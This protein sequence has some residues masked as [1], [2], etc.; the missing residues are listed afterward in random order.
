M[1]ADHDEGS[2]EVIARVL[3]EISSPEVNGEPIATGY[4]EGRDENILDFVL[5]LGHG[6]EHRYLRR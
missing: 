3:F 6:E 4:T 1:S 5:R 2:E